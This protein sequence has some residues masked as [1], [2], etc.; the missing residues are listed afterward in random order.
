MVTKWGAT[1]TFALALGLSGC[2]QNSIGTASAEA[3]SYIPDRVDVSFFYGQL[4]PYGRWID[5]APYGQCWVPYGVAAGWRP[6]SDGYWLYTDDGW[7]WEDYEP[8]GW[9]PFHYGRWV[10][11]ADFG[12][13]WVPGDVWAPAWVAWRDDD[14]WIGWAPLPPDAEWNASIGLAFFDADRIPEREWC[15]VPPHHFLDRD[16]HSELTSVRRNPM[17]FT[18]TH[19]VTRFAFH[20][21]RPMNRGVDP[22]RIENAIGRPVRPIRLL[23]ARGPLHG[24][25]QPRER[26]A[27]E[28]YRPEVHG[29]MRHFS[30][31][32]DTRGRQPWMA[33]ESPMR[34]RSEAAPRGFEM[35]QAQQRAQLERQRRNDLQPARD[36]GRM[37]QLRRSHE[38]VRPAF[39][40]GTTPQRPVSQDRWNPRPSARA[41]P[42]ERWRGPDRRYVPDRGPGPGS[43]RGPDRT[44][45]PDRG[46][47]QRDWRGPDRRY[48]P[49]RGPAPGSWR[50][51]DQAHGPDRGQGQRGGHGPDRGRA[52]DRAQDQGGGGNENRKPGRG[53]GHD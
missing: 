35:N 9:I 28:V 22:G 3:A 52:P 17:L 47:S 39:D 6:Y 48:V 31:P 11:D 1:V 29:N 21:G 42:A 10:F 36:H 23:D 26:G 19:N 34:R 33:S 25:Q 40:R 18:E 37:E 43:W 13:V 4:S 12:W 5:Y 46:Q 15:F 16:L 51:P 8:W 30:P 32:S 7:M 50:G 2:Y 45:A 20:D 53:H 27:M 38:G 49:D 44:Y 24:R 14:D 41:A